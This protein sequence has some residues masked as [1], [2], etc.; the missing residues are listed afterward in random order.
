MADPRALRNKRLE[1]EHKEL[2][3][4]NGEIIRIQPLG[5][6]PH[7]T[8]RVTFNVR[9][10]VHPQPVYR[11]RT[12]CLL[13]LPPSYPEGTPKIT[14]NDKPYPFHVNWF[15][16]GTWCHGRWNREESLANFLHRCA[17]TLQ[18]DPG[19]TNLGSPAN[20]EAKQFWLD[21]VGNKAVI[22]CDTQ[23]L[24]TLDL[25]ETIIINPLKI[26]QIAIIP[27]KEHHV[28]FKNANK[29]TIF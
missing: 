12:V 15:Q 27:D 17:R 25:P 22:P 8:Y 6:P 16:S 20:G 5:M 26:Q 21:N 9:T 19:I 23:E 29:I 3:A 28:V 13:Q 24:P 18:F 2:M 11:D 7:D 4:I 1:N 10:I 14:A